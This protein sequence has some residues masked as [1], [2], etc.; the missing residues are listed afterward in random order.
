MAASRESSDL[1]PPPNVW[2]AKIAQVIVRLLRNCPILD[3]SIVRLL[4]L[5]KQHSLLHVW[6][7]IWMYGQRLLEKTESYENM[8]TRRQDLNGESIRRRS[9]LREYHSKD[10][11][12]FTN[13]V[14]NVATA[15][16][17]F[18][19]TRRPETNKSCSSTTQKPSH[20]VSSEVSLPYTSVQTPHPRRRQRRMLIQKK[21][22]L[23]ER[24]P[25]YDHVVIAKD[26]LGGNRRNPA[27]KKKKNCTATPNRNAA[28]S[29]TQG[30]DNGGASEH[31]TLL[32]TPASEPATDLECRLPLSAT[33]GWKR[34]GCAGLTET[35]TTTA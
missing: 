5:G 10:T 24:G 16:T 27:Y 13:P 6:R 25:R 17:F 29:C 35:K 11:A 28:S 1:R 18:R 4:R 14:P 3:T 8:E 31:P 30:G 34:D 32:Q 19:H 20:Q 22:M 12:C 26:T 23:N 15:N 33:C 2:W 7:H 21:A 9:G